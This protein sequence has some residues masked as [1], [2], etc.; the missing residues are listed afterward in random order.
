MEEAMDLAELGF[1][2]RQAVRLLRGV[3]IALTHSSIEISVL[4]AVPWFKVCRKSFSLPYFA[5]SSIVKPSA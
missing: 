1:L 5:D 3:E 2:T 4:T